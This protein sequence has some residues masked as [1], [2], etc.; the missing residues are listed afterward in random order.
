M[1][2]KG[3]NLAPIGQARV[4]HVNTDSLYVYHWVT[5][6]LTGKARLNTKN[7]IEI[8]LKNVAEHTNFIDKG[9][10]HFLVD[11]TLVRFG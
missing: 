6:T 9:I 1:L 4:I 8:L 3:I 5:K 10:Q 7:T 2:L 11:I